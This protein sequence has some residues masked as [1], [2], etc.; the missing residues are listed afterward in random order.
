MLLAV[1]VP[2]IAVIVVF[3]CHQGR[4]NRAVDA[5]DH[6]TQEAGY[7]GPSVGGRT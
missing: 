4:L 5:M 7:V 2:I 6:A 3:T 1:F